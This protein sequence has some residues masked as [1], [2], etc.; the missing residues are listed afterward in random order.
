MVK[1]LLDDFKSGARDFME[2]WTPNDK[3]QVRVIYARS[4]TRRATTSARQSWW[5]ISSA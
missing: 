3:H 2:V 4:G 1:K 5:R